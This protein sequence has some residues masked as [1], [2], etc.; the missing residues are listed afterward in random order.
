MTENEIKEKLKTYICIEI[1]KNK[2]YPL[3]DDETM[4]SGGLVDSFSLVHIAVF[5]EKEIG[6]KIP[7][8]DLSVE[9]MDTIN[10]M[11]ERIMQELK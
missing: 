4:M 6:V 7:D 3:T 10:L 8:T 5:I 11:T 1:I 2:D 9:K